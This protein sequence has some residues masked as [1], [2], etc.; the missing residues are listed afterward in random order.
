MR[1]THKNCWEIKVDQYNDFTRPDEFIPNSIGHHAEWINAIK[2]GGTTTCN[3][4]YSGPL[5]EAVLLG[6]VAYKSGEK[7]NY[8]AKNGTLKNA[9]RATAHLHKEYRNGWKL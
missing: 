4:D 2:N 5:T 3:F 6:I 7:L 1:L 8:N 9:P